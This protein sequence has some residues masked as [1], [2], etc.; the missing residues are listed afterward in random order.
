M[1][2]WKTNILEPFCNIASILISMAFV[3]GIL[4][5]Q[6]ES[7]QIS[8]PRLSVEFVYVL[9]SLYKFVFKWY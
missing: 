5:R 3:F 6:G 8:F 2:D 1:I 7:L 9:T 4:N